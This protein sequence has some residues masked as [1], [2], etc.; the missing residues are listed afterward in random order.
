L[1]LQEDANKRL[2]ELEG[3]EGL[4]ARLAKERVQA[5]TK[6][7]SAAAELGGARRAASAALGVGAEAGL[8]RLAMPRAR[9]EV[10]VGGVA[11]GENRNKVTDEEADDSRE[12]SGEDVTFLLAANPGEPLLALSKVASG[13]SWRGRCSR[14]AWCSLA[15]RTGMRP[16]LTA[17]FRDL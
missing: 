3:L 10:K 8:R 16:G 4:S 15:G 1:T 6:L 7:R 12:L 14:C 13:G 9:F 17:M 2:D 11:Q 5:L